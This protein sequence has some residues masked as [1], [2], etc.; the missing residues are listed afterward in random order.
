M[1]YIEERLRALVLAEL[2]FD[3]PAGFEGE[4]EIELQ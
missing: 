4:V 2:P 3:M 1:S